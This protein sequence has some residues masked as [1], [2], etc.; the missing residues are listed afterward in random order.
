MRPNSGHSSLLIGGGIVVGIIAL[1]AV[2]PIFN[3]LTKF[4]G[5]DPGSVCV[6]QQGGWFDGRDIEK[7]RQPS[8]GVS[9]IGLYNSQRCFPATERNYII[10]ATS[11]EGDKGGVD[12]VKVPTS[13]AVDA[14]I[15]GQA[16][17]R[18]NTN[19]KVIKDFYKKFGVR[20]FDGKHPYEGDEGWRN[21][22]AIQF[23]PVLDNAL[24]EAIGK[25]RCVELNNTCQYVQNAEKA[26]GGKI[27]PVNNG[28]NLDK[29][30]QSI[31]EALQRDLNSTLGGPFFENIRF[32]LRGVKFA[33]RV[34]EEIENAQAKRTAV[35]S[36]KLEADRKVQE[37][38]GNRRQAVEKA[39]GERLS[40]QQQAAAIRATNSAYRGNPSKA[41]IDAIT[42]LCGDNG[43]PVSAVGTNLNS[44]VGK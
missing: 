9:F 11:G 43:C 17:F 12:T 10:S 32:R 13:D 7:V 21:F 33:P 31:A 6:V 38:I 37:A 4:K 27:Q 5:T 44:I 3:A 20:T 41:R 15:E 16:L 26:V 18:L 40:A 23:R 30:Q 19:E 39:T 29:A 24:R 14:Y 36:A 34:Q 28:Q 2:F 35:A 1:I 22:L 42:A 25:Y 8:E